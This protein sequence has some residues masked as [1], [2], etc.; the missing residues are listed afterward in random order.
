MHNSILKI[1]IVELDQI[2]KLGLHST[3]DD[4]RLKV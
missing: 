4:Q 2:K 1:L 3:D